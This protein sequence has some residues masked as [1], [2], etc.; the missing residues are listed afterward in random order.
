MKSNLAAMPALLVLAFTG[1]A[2]AQ[3]QDWRMDPAASRLEFIA[4][5]EKVEAPGLFREFDTRLRFDPDKP[6]GGR[7]EVTIRVSSA[8]MNSADINNAIRGPEWFDF[9]RFPQAEFRS[10]DIQRVAANR[11]IARGTLV[12]KGMQQAVEV[13]F[14]WQASRDAPVME[15][16]TTLRRGLFGI[17]LGEWKATDVIGADVRVKFRVRLRKGG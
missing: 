17:G 2:Q 12:L 8:D 11:F 1:P 7:L 10:S 3:M 6:A 16:E 4:S 9:A 15:G 13:P 14:T 5:F